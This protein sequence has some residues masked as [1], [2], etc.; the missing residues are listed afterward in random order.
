[1]GVSGVFEAVPRDLRGVLRLSQTISGGT[2]R[3]QGRFRG[4]QRRFEVLKAVSGSYLEVRGVHG[5]SRGTRR[6]Q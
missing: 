1:M 3:S 2:G 4:A 5:G 6:F